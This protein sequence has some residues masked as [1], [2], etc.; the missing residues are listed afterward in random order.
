MISLEM[1]TVGAL[2]T[3]YLTALKS[4]SDGFEKDWDADC[5][6][7]SLAILLKGTGRYRSF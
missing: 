2:L 1:E 3:E 4:Q 7:F 6:N 5:P